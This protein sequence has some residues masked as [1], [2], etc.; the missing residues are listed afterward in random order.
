MVTIAYITK[1]DISVV[2]G[3]FYS[4]QQTWKLNHKHDL[5]ICASCFLQNKAM[6]G[7]TVYSYIQ[8]NILYCMSYVRL[9]RLYMQDR[10]V[11]LFY[12]AL[13]L[14]DYKPMSATDN[15]LVPSVAHCS[16]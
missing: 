5:L 14:S 10:R 6:G 16:Q 1:V 15:V 7:R 4:I 2:Q 13:G 12:E 11:P 9:W 8:Y 3:L